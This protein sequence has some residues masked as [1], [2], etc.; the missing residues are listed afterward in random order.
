MPNSVLP[1]ETIDGQ[2][3]YE[4]TPSEP[5]IKYEDCLAE[6]IKQQCQTIR[7][8]TVNLLEVEISGVKDKSW[9]K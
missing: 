3:V 6:T 5:I 4:G 8:W 7:L 9:L 2:I 1:V